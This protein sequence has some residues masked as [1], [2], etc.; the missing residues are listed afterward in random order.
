MLLLIG[1]KA[2]KHHIPSWREPQ[3]TDYVGTYENLEELLKQHKGNIAAAYPINSGS[4]Y[5]IK[6][7][8]GSIIEMEIAWSGSRAEK[9]LE[10]VANEDDT[11]YA[12]DGAMVP[13]LDVLLLLK[14]S[15]KYLKDS[16][17][18]KKTMDDIHALR[19]VAKIRD[20]H[21]EFFKQREKDTYTYSH[22]R[23]K[24]TKDEFFD[25]KM[26]GVVQIF[27]HDQVHWAVKRLDSPAY[28][29]FKEDTSEVYCSSELFEKCPEEVKLLSVLEEAMVLAVERSLSVFVGK[30]TPRQAFEMAMMKVCTSITSGWWRAYAYENYYRVL[31]LYEDDWYDKFLDKVAKGEVEYNKNT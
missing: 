3:D 4:S 10:F 12:P 14:E 1:S 13:S 29:M 31:E 30:K 20:E 23:L 18:F 27:V 2:I 16:P 9:L 28:E 17:W 19:K 7:K 22:P 5:Y 24:V 21:R 15:H 26:N 25:A 6:L 8:S 11:E